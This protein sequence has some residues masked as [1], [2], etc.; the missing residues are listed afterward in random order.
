MAFSADGQELITAAVQQVQVR[1]LPEG[2]T[3]LRLDGATVAYP[4]AD[5]RLVTL[6]ALDARAV[7]SEPHSLKV[8]EFA[9]GQLLR[10]LP[11]DL[12]TL[13]WRNLPIAVS[14]DRR[15]L[16]FPRRL[17]DHQIQVW[18]VPG[19]IREVVRSGC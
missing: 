5:H 19:P 4:R 1:T 14:A 16:A 3:R 2:K 13:E 8:W 12:F 15:L 17:Y 18:N 7:G 9:T 11:A 10:T 6:A